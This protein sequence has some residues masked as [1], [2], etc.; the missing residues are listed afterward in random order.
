MTLIPARFLIRACHPCKHVKKMPLKSRDELIDLPESCR[1][2]NFAAMDGVKNFADV[3]L[4]WNEHGLGFQVTVRGKQQPLQADAAKPKLSDGVTLWID[5][6]DARTGHR[7]SRTCHQFH[8]LPTGGGSDK[9][10]PAFVP[11][12]IHRA[13]QDAPLPSASSVPFRSGMIKGGYRIEAFLTSAALTG[14]DP[15]EHP[16]LGIYY[17]VRDSELGE[18]T[19][20]VGHEFPFGEDPSLWEVLELV[21]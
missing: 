6:R 5:T 20:S 9:D 10:E 18:Q 15:E 12:K 14:F 13:L 3:R 17:A 11:A 7:A 16:R 19:L 21:K 4:A 8:F 2:D 1:L